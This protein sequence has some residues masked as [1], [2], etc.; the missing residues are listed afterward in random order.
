METTFSMVGSR[1]GLADPLDGEPACCL[2]LLQ[3]VSKCCGWG[4]PRK[5]RTH[6]MPR[7]ATKHNIR[8]AE[9]GL[10]ARPID[11]STENKRWNQGV[12]V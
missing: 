5:P 11:Q 6:V 2:L 10:Q 4:P 9:V 7:K 8:I 12:I 1:P 3:C